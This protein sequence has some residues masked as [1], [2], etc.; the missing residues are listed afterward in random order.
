MQGE[1]RTVHFLDL[2]DLLLVWRRER[3]WFT[4]EILRKEQWR[5]ESEQLRMR[6]GPD[7][8]AL[9]RASQKL[10]KLKESDERQRRM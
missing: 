4:G 9:L 6:G 7:G 1:V 8:V 2:L 10:E 5:E 3:D